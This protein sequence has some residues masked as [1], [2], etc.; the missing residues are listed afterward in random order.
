MSVFL[1][2]GGQVCVSGRVQI[3]LK[4]LLRW[5]I[6][7]WISCVSYGF[8][9]HVSIPCFCVKSCCMWEFPLISWSYSRMS[10]L[11]FALCPFPYCV[12]E[13]FGYV[14]DCGRY[15]SRFRS[16][17]CFYPCVA[18]IAVFQVTVLLAPVRYLVH[19][20]S[21]LDLAYCKLAIAHPCCFLFDPI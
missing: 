6:A 17:E 15:A 19:V 5:N 14:N 18:D 7:L 8:V 4:L 2:A 13:V 3:D 9:I 11:V 16:E 1:R 12:S 20:C 10:C 21:S